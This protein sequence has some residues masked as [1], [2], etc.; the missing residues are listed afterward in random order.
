MGQFG[1]ISSLAD[2]PAVEILIEYIKNAA[3]LNET[4]VKLPQKTK[5]AITVTKIQVPQYF[6]EALLKNVLAQST[7]QSFSYSHRKEYIEWI[8]EV[9]TEATCQKRMATALLWLSESK[10]RNWKYEK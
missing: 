7:F 3:L 2:L 8:T 9:K 5:V 10:R 4:G 6:A 1:R